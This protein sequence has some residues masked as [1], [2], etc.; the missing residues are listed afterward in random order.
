MALSDVK[1]SE[2]GVSVRLY[3]VCINNGIETIGQLVNIYRQIGP[4]GMKRDLKNCSGSVIKDVAD[5]VRKV[6][7][8]E[9]TKPSAPSNDEVVSIFESLQEQTDIMGGT[10]AEF[11]MLRPDGF[12][13]ILTVLT[14]NHP[15]AMKL[16]ESEE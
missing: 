1:I 11:K 8:I 4:D 6:N 10:K 5:I 14:P 13:W 15:D 2:Y 3:N 9:G 16:D 12:T 7:L